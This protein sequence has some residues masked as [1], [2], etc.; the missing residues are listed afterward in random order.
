MKENFI[1]GIP[2][3]V[4]EVLSPGTADYDRRTKYNLYAS[5][6]IPEYWIVD[7]DGCVIEV[8]ALRGNAYVPLGSFGRGSELQSELLPDLRIVL[9]EICAAS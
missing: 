7:P 5:A 9:D 4:I 3:L 6:G 8:F 2:D 1:E